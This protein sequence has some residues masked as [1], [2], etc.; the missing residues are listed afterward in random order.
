MLK[1]KNSR[2]E[3]KSKDKKNKNKQIKKAVDWCSKAEEYYDSWQYQETI[4]CCNHV[5][6]P[7]SSSPVELD[8]YLSALHFKGLAYS[9]LKKYDFAIQSF[10]KTIETRS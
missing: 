6:A 10:K 7:T 5:S 4:D 9:A 3:K 2:R 1:H 8:N